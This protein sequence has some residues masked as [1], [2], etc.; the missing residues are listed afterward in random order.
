MRQHY[1]NAISMLLRDSEQIFLQ[2]ELAVI[3]RN[4]NLKSVLR[5]KSWVVAFYRPG[6]LQAFARHCA[7]EWRSAFRR[8]PRVKVEY[9]KMIYSL[10]LVA[11][12][13]L[14]R[15]SIQFDSYIIGEIRWGANAVYTV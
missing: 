2:H 11:S 3:G 7:E 8:I 15:A 5:A 9:R 12:S 6:G 1:F 14:R 13:S 10:F 4:L